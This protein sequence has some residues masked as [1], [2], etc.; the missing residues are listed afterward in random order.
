MLNVMV[1]RRRGHP[2]SQKHACSQIWLLMLMLA[3]AACASTPRS[4]GTVPDAELVQLVQGRLAAVVEIRHETIAVQ[5]HDGVVELSGTAGSAAEIR[6]ILR[7][8]GRVDGVRAVVNR[9][10]ILT[11]E[12]SAGAGPSP[13]ER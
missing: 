12:P 11:R 6:R 5:A 2:R 10:R 7:E 8:V 4:A 3:A 13:V 1:T 9:L